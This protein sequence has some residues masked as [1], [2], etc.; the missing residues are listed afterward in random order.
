MTDYYK[1]LNVSEN[2]S[3][4]EIKKS[5]RILA[6]KYHPDANPNDKQAETKFKEI[7][8]AYSVLTDPK[9]KQQYDMMRKYGAGFGSGGAGSQ[10]G[11]MGGFSFEDIMAQFGGGSQNASGRGAQFTGFG[12][13]ADIFSS[14]FG[15]QQHA[16]FGK[17]GA[18]R[19]NAP[20][21]GKDVL[22]DIEIPFEDAV[23][24]GKKSVRLNMEQPCDQCRGTGV[25]SSSRAAVCPECKGRGNVTFSQGSFAVSRPCPRCLGRGQ[26][27]GDPCR[28]CSGSGKTFGPREIK[29]NIPGGIESGRKIRLKGLGQPGINGGPNGDLYLKINVSGHQY[30]WRKGKDIYCKVPI[31]IKQAVLGSKIKIRT[32]T[33]QVEL[34]I[35]PG[36]SSG[37]RFRL[38]GLGLSVNGVK[39]DQFVEVEVEVPKNLTSEQKELF[40]KF[41]DSM[42]LR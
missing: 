34:K 1:V 4:P 42:K 6:K 23:K 12:S 40:G 36:T 31:N 18:R 29:I 27:I 37:K 41:A 28:K 16:G 32:L 25:T 2:A 8:E 9:K 20:Q 38:R 5:Y 33:N 39:G 17:T 19:Q 13:F 11:G 21:K 7:S 3:S 15:E 24:G 22:T 10:T 30:F 26:I 14:M 35:P